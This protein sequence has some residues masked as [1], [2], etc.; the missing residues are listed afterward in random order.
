MSFIKKITRKKI[1][2]PLVLIAGLGGYVV[3]TQS[4]PAPVEF[5]STA[6]ERIDLVQSVE[7]TGTVKS[8]TDLSYG[9]EISGRVSEITRRVGEEVVAGDVIAQLENSQ[10]L[11][12]LRESQSLLAAAQAQLNLRLSGPSTEQ[13]A[14]SEAAIASAQAALLQAQT[15]KTNTL[16]AGENNIAAAERSV[17]QATSAVDTTLEADQQDIDEAYV[18][19]VEVS[20]SSLTT[21]LDVLTVVADLQDTYVELIDGFPYGINVVESKKDAVLLLLGEE[22]SGRRK[23]EYL[24]SLKGGARGLVDDLSTQSDQDAIDTAIAALEQSLVAVREMTS[25]ALT[26]LNRASSVSATDESALVSARSSI[27]SAISSL[28]AARQGISSEILAKTNNFASNDLALQVAVQ[29]LENARSAAQQNNASAE[30]DVI[31]AEAALAQ[32]RANH[33]ELTADPRSVDVASLRADVSRQAANVA[34]AEEGLEKT[35]LIALSDGVISKLDIEVG[36]TVTAN[37]EIFSLVSSDLNIE[38]DISET[39]IAKIQEGDIAEITLDAFGDDRVFNGSVASIEPAETEISG[40]VYYKTTVLLDLDETN[41]QGVRPGMTANVRIISDTRSSVLV[42]PRR[43]VLTNEQ[44]TYVRVLTNSDTA[45]YEEQQITTGVE[46]D[47]GLIEV[48][49]GLSEGLEVITFI[50]EE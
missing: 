13:I 46:G 14:S 8:Q 18:S 29:N 38:V 17:A 50:R 9:W 25:Y 5:S 40:V 1:W 34:I 23:A 48:V 16:L 12:R 43:A 2:I 36:E 33:Q 6:V 37:Q 11:S 19:A 30:A 7:E 15:R 44:G 41:Q 31:A 39:D 35:Q 3:Y 10:E 28:I 20:K 45:A 47:D 32:A 49:S 27:N 21:G 42:I 24:L 4:Q 22:T 26:A